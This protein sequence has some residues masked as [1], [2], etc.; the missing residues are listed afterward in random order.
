M[1]Y[2][3]GSGGS[4][5]GGDDADSQRHAVHANVQKASDHASKDEPADGPKVNRQFSPFV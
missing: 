5:K 3:I 4:V 1:E 2:D